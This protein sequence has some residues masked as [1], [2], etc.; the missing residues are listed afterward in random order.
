MKNSAPGSSRTIAWITLGTGFVAVILVIFAWLIFYQVQVEDSLTGII[1]MAVGLATAVFFAALLVGN[2]L[3]PQ[4]IRVRLGASFIFMAILPAVG[5]SIGAA[6]LGYVDSRQRATNQL[7][8]VAALR[9]LEFSTWSRS[10]QNVLETA[11]NEQLAAER[12]SILLDLAN[13]DKH[14]EYYN[15]AMRTRLRLLL[16]NKSLQIDELLLVDLRGNIAVSTVIDHEGKQIGDLPFFKKGLSNAIVDLPFQPSGSLWPAGNWIFAARPVIDATGQV[17]GI[18]AARLGPQPLL[19]ILADQTGLGS[20]GRLYLAEPAGALLLTE[21][22]TAGLAAARELRL[23]PMDQPVAD[24]VGRSGLYRGFSGEQVVSAYR[25]LSGLGV[26][27]AVEQDQSEAFGSTYTTLAVNLSISLLAV[28]LAAI[29]SFLITRSITN[30]LVDLAEAASHI[31]LGEL[32]RTVKVRENDEVGMVA[33][34]FNSMTGQLRDLIANLEQRVADRTRALQDAIQTQQRYSLQLETNAKVSRK[35]T[36]ILT[37]DDLLNRVVVL[38][39]E[40]FG[41]YHIHIGLVEKGELVMQASTGQPQPSIFHISVDLPCL[42]NWAIH[43]G[44]PVLANDVS[45]EPLF[46]FDSRSPNTRAELVIPLQFADAV[47]GTMDV[48]SESVNAFSEQDITVLTS[49]GDQVAIAI[50]NARRYARIRELVAVEERNRIARDLHDSVTQSLSSLNILLEGWRRLV[51]AGNSYRIETFLE[52][53]AQINDQALK[54]MRMMVHELRPSTLS[55]DGLID[56]LHHRIEVVEKRFGIDARVIAEELL[57]LPPQVEEELYWITHEALNNSLKHSGAARVS[58]TIRMKD[59]GLVLEVAD[60]GCGFTYNAETTVRGEGLSG[61]AERVRQLGG[62]LEVITASGSGT[63]IRV[64]VPV[65]SIDNSREP[66][67]RQDK[68]GSPL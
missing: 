52:R 15:G 50:E 39:K 6:A 62:A 64:T 51:A 23:V 2:R 12:A 33:L 25:T 44:K 60:N 9:D 29:A 26:V 18:I 36:S 35:I 21:S 31:A 20:T 59:G 3:K 57:A 38:I 58:V 63:T 41:Y 46:V 34:A 55:Q 11:L 32:D 19:D 48:V 1:L 68:E 56:T 5:I 30:P 10:V 61:M 65:V 13:S 54:E 27:L 47:I 45:Q 22:S 67:K 7:E 66:V 40:S 53:V 28:L 14:S 8:S 24:R 42:N 17:L 16:M 49:L 4:T 37:I 43:T